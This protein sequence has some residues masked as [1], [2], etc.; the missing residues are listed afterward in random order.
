MLRWFP[1]LQVATACFLCSPPGLN[2][3]DP[4]FTFMYAHN[5]HCHRATAHWQF[6]IIIIIIIG[7]V[8]LG[9]PL[10]KTECSDGSQHFKLLL[11]ASYVALRTAG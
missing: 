2:F 9:F 3:L 7:K 4:Y 11:H 8:F 6:I 1:T 10:S 5:N